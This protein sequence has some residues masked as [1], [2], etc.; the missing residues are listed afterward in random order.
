M[1]NHSRETG[2][3]KAYTSGYDKGRSDE[4]KRLY[5]V[6]R[7]LHRGDE[8]GGGGS[9]TPSYYEIPVPEHISS[10]GTIIEPHTEII[11]VLEP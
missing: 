7:N 11:E 10:D 4:V 3:V 2:K 8:F 1:L 5:W 6:Q 9:L